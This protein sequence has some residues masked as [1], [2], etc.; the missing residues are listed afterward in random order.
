MAI[1]GIREEKE[2][3]V[4]LGG[5]WEGIQLSVLRVAPRL[6]GCMGGTS[7]SMRLLDKLVV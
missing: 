5:N 6:G 3:G 7:L 1:V 2:H 4:G